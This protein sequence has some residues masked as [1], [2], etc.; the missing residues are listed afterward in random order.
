MASD[1]LFVRP[2]KGSADKFEADQVFSYEG[3]ALAPV[4]ILSSQAE[5]RLVS[6][7]TWCFTRISTA[8]HQ[9]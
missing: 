4:L 3:R 9:K 2:F 6:S 1:A 5:K 8:L 7:S